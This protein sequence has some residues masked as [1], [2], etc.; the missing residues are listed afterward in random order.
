MAQ[1]PK[2]HNGKQDYLEYKREEQDRNTVRV[3]GQYGN[4]EVKEDSASNKNYAD[5]DNSPFA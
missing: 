5:K 1:K 2:G 4:D 3:P